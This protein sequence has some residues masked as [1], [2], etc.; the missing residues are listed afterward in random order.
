MAIA[1]MMVVT[2]YSNKS[3]DYTIPDLSMLAVPHVPGVPTVS[4]SVWQNPSAAAAARMQPPVPAGHAPSWD[5]TMTARPSYPP[6]A[7]A[8][9]G[10][11]YPPSTYPMYS[12]ASMPMGPHLLPWLIMLSPA[13]LS[14][15]SL[16]IRSLEGLHKM[17]N[18]LITAVEPPRLRGAA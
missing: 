14:L 1:S 13:Q 10:Q 12:P 4:G 15:G 9:P 6:A 2:A 8:F 16:R 17:N 11:G 7:G 5:P 3:R 18:H